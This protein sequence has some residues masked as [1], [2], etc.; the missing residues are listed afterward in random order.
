M[1]LALAVSQVPELGGRGCWWLL[2]DLPV[3]AA[4]DALRVVEPYRRS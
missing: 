1:K 3:A 4:Q 2:T